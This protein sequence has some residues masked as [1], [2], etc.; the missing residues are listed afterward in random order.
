M[1]LPPE[2]LIERTQNK[3][4]IRKWKLI[5]ISLFAVSAVISLSMLG[6]KNLPMA[7]VTISPYIASVAIDGVLFEDAKRD[8]NLENI[9]DDNN[10]KALI[11]YVDSPGGTVVGG[12]KIYNILRKISSKKPVV[13]VLGTLATSAGYLIALGG[14]YIISH[15]GTITGSIGVIMQ[16]A[17][18]TELAEK[19][20]VKLNNFKSSPLKAAPNPTE[21]LTPEVQE[22]IMESVA[23]AY[24]YFIEVVAERRGLSLEQVRKIAD[25]RIYLGKKA[26]KLKLVD[27][28]GTKDDAVKWLQGQKQ[29]DPNLKVKEVKLKPVN[30]FLD[31]LFEDMDSL[32]NNI[33]G[34]KNQGVTAK[35]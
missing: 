31:M 16:S 5:A 21:K 2:Y 22:A 33:F 19:L 10:I 18:I 24:D 29:I 23:D 11:L 28:V 9:A 25:G 7:A 8:T 20:G 27:A 32:A 34:Y 3:S 12:E 30:K 17:E 15:N 14:D 1:N 35:F 13:V 6:G 4:Q 26:L